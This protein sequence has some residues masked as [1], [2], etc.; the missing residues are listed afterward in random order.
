MFT[1]QT[2]D[3]KGNHTG[4][5]TAELIGLI[6]YGMTVGVALAAPI[7]PI[8]IEIIRR[9]IRDGFFHGWMVGLGA[10]SVDT[11]YAM[12]IV[13]GFASFAD[14]DP[15][16]MVLYLAGGLMLGW[17]GFGSAKTALRG[18][19]GDPND[20]PKPRGRSYM[21]GVL[22]AAF[23]PMGIIYWLTVGAG[24]AA[25]AVSRVGQSGAPMLV[26]GVTLGIFLWVSTLSVIA[27]VSRRFVT[28]NGMR[29]VTGISGA[30]LIGFAL[31]FFW[32]GFAIVLA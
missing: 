32:Q 8:N 17:V 31:F 29:W 30:I 3:S 18:L 28:G 11:V 16:R 24:L 6:V 27:Q 13:S 9:G 19:E 21:T 14:N 10:L 26:V 4:M 15:I 22:M 23:N 7:G 25:D 12:I 2:A 1:I 20:K 5:S